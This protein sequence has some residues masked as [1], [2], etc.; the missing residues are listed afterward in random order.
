MLLIIYLSV[1]ANEQT[2]SIWSTDMEASLV[3]E[4]ALGRTK[5]K[6]CITFVALLLSRTV[7]EP[8]KHTLAARLWLVAGIRH[9]CNLIHLVTRAAGWIRLC[10]GYA[11]ACTLS[12]MAIRTLRGTA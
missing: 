6:Q 3:Q 8:R 11:R 9:V 1:L 12:V 2:A 7:S 5:S 4:I 10:L